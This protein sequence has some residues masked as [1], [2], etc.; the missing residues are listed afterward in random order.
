MTRPLL[1]GLAAFAVSCGGGGGAD[2]P[3]GSS[4]KNPTS[5]YEDADFD[6]Y[7]DPDVTVELCD[8]DDPTGT[9]ENGDDCDDRSV[10]VNPGEDEACNGRDDDCDGEVDEDASGA[11]TWYED[12][13]GDGFGSDVSIETA[14]AIPAGFVA[15]GGDCDD[16]DPD[17][18][19]AENEVCDLVD[20]D[21]IGVVDDP[22]QLPVQTYYQDLDGD[23]YGEPKSGLDACVEP[24]GYTWND[25]DCDDSDAGAYPDAEEVCGDL[26]DSNCDGED[27]LDWIV[28]F[29]SGIGSEWNL[30]TPA[31]SLSATAY[32]GSNG[33]QNGDIA[34]SQSTSAVVEVE[35]IEDGTLSYWH[36]ESTESNYDYLR[37]YIDGEQQGQWSGTGSWRQETHEMTAGVYELKWE[38]S[39]DGSVSTGAD[40]VYV[41]LIE[42]FGAV[43]LE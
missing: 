41:D 33:F 29:E 1:V 28:D 39:K 22:Y 16:R 9:S 14:C 40:T 4:C 2:D 36:S 21:C 18:S 32:E 19:P 43:A 26:V 20:N 31:W 38:Y 30:G 37:F 42:A 8:G 25:F 13:D 23:G 34:D 11:P 7:G 24:S 5:V 10:S 6:G 3:N 27:C 12:A 17:V 35:F 15:K